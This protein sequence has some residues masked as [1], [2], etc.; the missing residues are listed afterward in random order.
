MK[1]M[2][3][4]FKGFIQQG[5]IVTIA[6]GLIM[7]LYFQKIVEALLD[8]VINPIIAAIFGK[9]DFTAIG[10]D[11]GKARISI[12][13]VIDAAISFVLVAFILFLL[14]KAYNNMKKPAAEE[15]AG[16]TEIELLTEIRDSLRAR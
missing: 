5:D 6:V 10:F 3:D 4:E 8:G 11:I 9:P 14:L 13:L 16:P 12:G 1:K 7:A 2:L 15:D